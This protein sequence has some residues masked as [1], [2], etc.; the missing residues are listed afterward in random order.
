MDP[1]TT[2]APFEHLMFADDRP[3]YPMTFFLRARLDGPLAATALR[4]AATAAL[5][6]HPLLTATI[7]GGDARAKGAELS[8]SVPEQAAVFL[9]DAPEGTPF[10]YPRGTAH[11]DITAEAGVRLF[12]RGP[13]LWLQTHHAAADANG[14][15]QFLEDVLIAYADAAG[16]AVTARPLVPALLAGRAAFH[17]TPRDQR[18]RRLGVL[19]RIWL[20]SR[21]FPAPLTPARGEAVPRTITPAQFPS[22][23]DQTL[24]ESEALALRGE[25]HRYGATVNDLML[26]DL[27]RALDTWNRDHDARRNLRLAM[28]INMRLGADRAMPA[29]NVVSMCFLDRKG[30][31]LDAPDLLEG[32]VRETRAIKHFRL[33]HALLIV[34]AALSRVPGGLKL[35]VTARRPWGCSAT[36]VLS[37]LGTPFFA[38]ALPRDGRGRLRVGPLTLA[39]LELLPPIRPE[40]RAA[41]GVVNYG[42]ELRVTLHFDARWLTPVSARALLNGFLATLRQSMAAAAAASQPFAARLAASKIRRASAPF[43]GLPIGKNV[44]YGLLLAPGSP[45]A[46]PVEAR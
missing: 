33:G 35:L 30:A 34:A 8:W 46:P 16:A 43:R 42:G 7:V 13:W 14:A 2:L 21:Q 36:A 32:I 25:A 28:P 3:E 6:R 15:V 39:S 17:V 4:A 29:A 23:V 37:N 20:F 24:S 9:D 41:I 19:H 5:A 45:K 18:R 22:C 38:S 26:A 12:L 11:L 44:G 40:T 1:L 10:R 27:F 31:A